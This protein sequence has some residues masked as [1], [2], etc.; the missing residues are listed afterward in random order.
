MEYSSFSGKKLFF[1]VFQDVTFYLIMFCK[2]IIKR[3][4]YCVKKPKTPKKKTATKN[5]PE[6]AAKEPAAKKPAAKK[7][8]PQRRHDK[9]LNFSNIVYCNCFSYRC[10][11]DST[12]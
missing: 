10:K 6:K 9:C 8:R 5:T 12:H 3:E 1:A 4:N 7:R 2:S 11:I